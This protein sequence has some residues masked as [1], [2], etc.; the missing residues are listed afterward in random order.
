MNAFAGLVLSFLLPI[1]NQFNFSLE[2]VFLQNDP[3]RLERLLPLDSPV[4]ITLPEPFQVSDCFSRQQASQI[5]KK[6]FQHTTTL[7]FFIDQENQP[8][9]DRKGAIIQARWSTAD[10]RDGRKYL[11]KLYLYVFPEKT[12]GR[13]SLSLLKIREIRAEKR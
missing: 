7:E 12:A 3:A 1:I 13:G 2:G 4:L 9:L 6:L 5:M 8:V 10:R 11:F